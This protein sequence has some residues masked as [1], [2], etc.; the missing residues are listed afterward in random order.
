MLRYVKVLLFTLFSFSMNA[1]INNIIIT[2]T[3]IDNNSKAPVEFATVMITETATDNTI[4]GTTTDETGS[5][6]LSSNTQNIAIS[7]SFIGYETKTITD[8]EVVNGE[9]RL[10]EIILSQDGEMLDEVVVRAEKSTTEFKLDKRVFNVGQD[11]SS[12]GA[13]ALDV[14][15]NVPSVN[16]NIEGQVS[17]RGSQGVQILING[18]P[19]VLASEQGNALGTL[20]ADMIEKVEVIT[21]PSAKYEAEGTS[22][23]INIV[24][25]KEEKKGLNGA[26]SLNVGVPENHSVGVSLNRRTDKFNLFSQF[27]AGTR[28]LPRYGYTENNNLIQ[29]TT[30]ISDGVEYRNEQFYNVVLGTDYHINEY[31]VM[32]LS[33]NFA[34][35]VEDQPSERAFEL[36]DAMGNLQSAWD[37]TEVT[38]AGNPKYQYEFQYKKEFPNDKDHFI[39]FSALGNFFGKEQ[40]SE[41]MNVYALGDASNNLQQRTSSDFQEAKYTFNLDY[42]NP[43]NEKVTIET[44]AQYVI[45]DVGNDYSVSNLED[46]EYVIDPTFTNNFIYEQDVLGVYATGA[47]E[48]QKFGLKF[49][50]RAENTDL[51]TFLENTG[52]RNNQ[53]FTNLFPSFH[54]SYK[55]TDGFS[56]QA[57][58]SRRI[59]RPRLWDLNPFFNIRDQYNIRTGN[60]NL[61]PEFTDSYEITS[62]HIWEKVSVNFGVYYRYTTDVVES[63]TAYNEGVSV[64]MPQNIGINQAVG[65]EFN[66]K[67]NPVKWYALNTDFNANYFNRQGQLNERNFDFGAYQ[68]SIR[69]LNKIKLPADIEMEITGNYRSRVRSVQRVQKDQIFADFGL[70]KKIL[71]GKLIVNLS[72]RDVFASRISE[73]FIDQASFSIYDRDYRGRFTSLGISYGFGKGE[74]MEYSGRRHH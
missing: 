15:T 49:G 67:L 48:D 60:P 5:F 52:E 32:T 70:R 16:V 10:G 30:L 68:Y 3:I 69:L 19:S 11:L 9:I 7:V 55:I 29:N 2:G 71:K 45:N 40:A 8:F 33:G 56:V 65:L 66:G 41:F 27:G 57:G 50:L 25:K 73:G 59:F 42:T 53:N 46:G 22:G 37:R 62:I 47:Y 4:T 35:E 18:K 63:V 51:N 26:V 20:T 34:Y 24:L 38:E 58:Y 61:M 31:N 36:Y 13:S 17:L 43:V 12:A 21:N 28:S 74:A 39:L 1:Q 23:I 44:G 6:E 54:T 64:V 72:V 14:L